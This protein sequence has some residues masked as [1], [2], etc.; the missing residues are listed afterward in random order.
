M[1]ETPGN[2]SPARTTPQHRELDGFA[3]DSFQPAR[4]A[5]ARRATS[6]R[7][8][9]FSQMR[10]LQAALVAA[11]V[12]A[13]CDDRTAPVSL[14]EET[15]VKVG[16]LVSGV[17]TFSNG[18][19]IAVDEVN[20]RGGLLGRSVELIGRMGLAEAAEAVDTAEAMILGDEVVALI[21]PNRSAHAIMV[22]AVAQRHGVPMVTTAAT[23]PGVTAAGD[24][25]F[26]AAFTDQFQGR[27]MADFAFEMLGTTTAA[28]LT[29]RG[30]VYSEGIGDFFVAHFRSLGGTIVADESYERGQTD[31]TMQLTE[32]AASAP[33]ALFLPGSDEEVALLTAQ[34]RALPLRDADGE[35]TVF[36]GGRCVGQPGAAGTRGSRR[37]W[38]L[39]QHSLLAGHRRA[40]RTRIRRY[41]SYAVRDRPR[42]RRRGELRCGPAVS[43]GRRPGGQSRCGCRPAGIA[44]YRTVCRG[45]IYLTLQRSSPSDQERGHHDHR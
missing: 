27:V 22:G 31:F 8:K 15:P 10:L 29:E 13:A 40:G 1:P 25:V 21:G 12:L 11:T 33:A 20:G 30:N 45:D 23:N 35:P 42:G 36:L 26:M 34:A 6:R 2:R 7:D 28:V 38:Q 39:L 18:A 24:L 14:D 5:R 4:A 41:L 44:G 32:I 9:S 17:R 43:G 3:P 16:F 37:G 19:M